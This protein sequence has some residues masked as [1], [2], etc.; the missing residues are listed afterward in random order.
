M[1]HWLKQIAAGVMLAGSAIGAKY[2]R[3]AGETYDG[4]PKD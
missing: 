2:T 1:A 4:R 3:N